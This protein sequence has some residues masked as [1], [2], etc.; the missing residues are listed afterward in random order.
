MFQ[1]LRTP[2]GYCSNISRCVKD[3][4]NKISCMKSHDHHVFLEQLLP[5]A[6]RGLLPKH[7]CEPLIELS[8]FFKNLCSKNLT[9]KELDK[10]ENKIPYTMCK[11]EMIFPP[12]FFSVMLHL[13]VHLVVAEAKI[14][15]PVRY[16]WMYPIERY[17][18]TL[19]SY[20]RNKARPEGSIA[21]GYLAD[22]CLTF[23]SR[24]MDD[25]TTKFSRHSRNEDKDGNSQETSK[26]DLD[27]FIPR[28]RPLGKSTPHHLTVEEF[29]QVHFHTL[30]NCDD[31]MELAKQHRELLAAENPTPRSIEKRHKAQ[32]S[33]WVRNHI[34]Q[35]EDKLSYENL[36]ALEIE[37]L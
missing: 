6:V 10:L 9:M 11:L 31:L 36:E 12:S 18:R 2:D 26:R 17:L 8:L 24:Y 23:C 15:G 37:K 27:L 33:E 25:M 19:K 35:E 32:F 5:I 1:N 29:E 28:G 22:E 4:G 7:V 21:R 16:R 20:V 14:G 13:V 30:N 34:W 3:N